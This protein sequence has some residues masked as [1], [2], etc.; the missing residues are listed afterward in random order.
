MSKESQAVAVT[1]LILALRR[2]RQAELLSSMTAR[3][4]QGYTQREIHTHTHIYI[5]IYILVLFC[6]FLFVCLFVFVFVCLLLFFQDWVSPCSP[7]CPG[8]H[9]VYQA[10]L[11]LRNLPASA[12]GI[13]GVHHLA[14]LFFLFF[15]ISKHGL[16]LPWL[17]LNSLYS[18]D[19]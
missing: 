1:P 13:K 11:E 16:K 6:F 18:P 10:G 14:R 19:R 2:Q 5:Y 7:G 4:T 3:A 9:F 12:S 15:K 17:A 8:T